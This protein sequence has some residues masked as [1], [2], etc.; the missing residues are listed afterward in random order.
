MYGYRYTGIYRFSSYDTSGDTD[1]C[2]QSVL[3]VP[4]RR[5]CKQDPIMGFS[6]F[7]SRHHQEDSRLQFCAQFLCRRSY[8]PR[9]EEKRD[10]NTNGHT[11]RR[12]LF[13]SP[14]FNPSLKYH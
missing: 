11:F 6:D 7:V 10:T 13:T 9:Y 8:S 12:A 2:G 1:L 14:G 5:P 4:L 3:V